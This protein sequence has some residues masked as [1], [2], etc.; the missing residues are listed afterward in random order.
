MKGE[1]NMLKVILGRCEDILYDPNSY[2][3]LEFEEEWML[4]PIIKDNIKDIDKSNL[5]APNLIESP[6]LGPIPPQYL[7]GGTKTLILILN[8]DREIFNASACGDNCAKWLLEIAKDRD[9][10][11]NLRHV[12]KFSEPF[13]IEIINTNKKV[14]TMHEFAKECLLGIGE[15]SSYK[16]GV[17]VS[18]ER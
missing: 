2:F 7:S 5:V 10:I 13:E 4:N 11:V 9:I 1:I 15:R 12:M 18:Y 14:H 8:D 3:D 17:F 6:K 16:E